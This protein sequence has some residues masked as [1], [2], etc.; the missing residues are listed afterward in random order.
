M[1]ILFYLGHPAHF[2]LFK[3]TIKI[4]KENNHTVFLTIRKKDVLEELLNPTGWEYWNFMPKGRKDNKVS[5]A[6][7]L[8]RRTF[9]MLF[10]CFKNKPDIMLGYSTEITHVGKLLHIPSVIVNEDDYTALPIF[11]KL[12]HPFVSYILAPESVATGPANGEWEKKT[13]H[14]RGYHELAYLTPDRFNPDMNRIS[15]VIDTTKRFFIIRF[16]KLTAHHDDGITGITNKLTKKIISL[17][18]PYGNIYITSER[19]L[20][21]EFLPYRININ[22]NDIH[23]ALFFADMFI[24]DSQTMAIEAAV[25][26]TPSLRFNDFVGELGCIEELE[27]KYKLTCGIKTNEPEKLLNKIKEYL[28][29][30]NLKHIWHQRKIDMLNDTINL[31]AFM[32]WFIEN[33]PKSVDILKNNPDY[34]NKFKLKNK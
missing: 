7:G 26:G 5:I 19:E 29:T 25:L 22:P 1:K 12:G 9:K 30:P 18:E 21:S 27:H 13:F 15:D 4:L 31:T 23:H 20:E 8:I 24:G 33:Y 10:F 2:H 11:S 16:A 14:Y 32:V 34:Q 6:F 28:E 3:N 17:L